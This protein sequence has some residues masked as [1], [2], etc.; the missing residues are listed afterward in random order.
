MRALWCE[1]LRLNAH[2]QGT[3]FLHVLK[4][5]DHRWDAFGRAWE[6][7]IAEG[8]DTTITE[9]H[10]PLATVFLYDGWDCSLPPYVRKLFGLRDSNGNFE[11]GSLAYM[12]DHG[13]TFEE[14][15]Q[16]IERGPRGLFYEEE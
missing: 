11:G 9:Q 3:F 8:L 16:I 6:I 15:A 12:A 14:V 4:D 2:R 1:D 5:S 7:A 10:E 13:L